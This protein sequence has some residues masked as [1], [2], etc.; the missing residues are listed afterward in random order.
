MLE[1]ILNLLTSNDRKRFLFLFILLLLGALMEMIGLATIVPLISSFENS[2]ITLPFT[3]INLDYLN[4]SQLLLIIFGFIIIIK[5]IILIIINFYQHKTLKEFKASLTKRLFIKYLKINF[6]NFE[7]LS[8][9]EFLRNLNTETGNV[10]TYLHSLTVVIIE[11]FLSGSIILTLLYLKPFETILSTLYLLIFTILY[12]FILKKKI[13]IWGKERLTL[14]KKTNN[15]FLES[16]NGIIQIKY[17]NLIKF[18]SEKST[19]LLNRIAQIQIKRSVVS[20][21]FKYYVE[22]VVF[23][24]GIIY[25]LVYSSEKTSSYIFS[26]ISLFLFAIL[27]ILPSSNRIIGM[28]QNLNFFNSSVKKIEKELSLNTEADLQKNFLFNDEIKGIVSYSYSK[29]ENN[30]IHN[31]KFNILKNKII[32]LWGK[33]GTGKSTFIKIIS[34][35]YDDYEGRILVDQVEM[36][37]YST[38][39]KS[40][41]GLLTQ[42]NFLMND[43]LK[44]N[45]S[46]NEK[47]NEEKIMNLFK[48]LS[49]LKYLK[50]FE[51]GLD[52]IIEENGKNLS[53]GQKQ[54][55]NLVRILYQDP[56]IL[57]LDEPTTSLDKYATLAIK[58]AIKSLKGK[59]TIIIS[60]HKK[61]LLDLADFVYYF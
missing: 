53:G 55:I 58:N 19:I 12:Y 13:N 22:I 25:F 51:N 36:S 47:A 32:G 18:Y 24:G 44:F 54:I 3:I 20:E 50:S 33:S 29:G 52:T 28:Y 7:N 5:S 11:G 37:N 61:Q 40:K 41:V 49:L 60:S 56:E 46:L 30:V 14:E 10:N 45:I 43:T 39:I 38:S 42:A 26:T 23:L 15:V 8:S 35:L 1:N 48:S 2:N 4:N 21:V 59:K 6:K 17:F 27:R 57:I 9:G 16:Y 34:G 31:F